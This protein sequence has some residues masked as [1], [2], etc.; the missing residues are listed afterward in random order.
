MS[1]PARPSSPEKVVPFRRVPELDS[2]RALAAAA[3][4]LFHLNP[5]Q[6]AFGWT[7][8]DLFFVLSG[9][10]ITKIIL[11]NA[12]SRG[13]FRNFYMRRGLRIWPIYYLSLFVIV[14]LNNYLSRPQD[15]TDLPYY[16]TY[17]QNVQ[18]Y[19]HREPT[20]FHVAFR[21]TWTLAL[22]EQ[23]YLIWPALVMLVRRKGLIALCLAVVA[24]AYGWRDMAFSNA[25]YSLYILPSRCDGFAL[26]GLP[27]CGRPGTRGVDQEELTASP[28]DLSEETIGDVPTLCG[29]PSPAPGSRAAWSSRAP[30]GHLH[31][32]PAVAPARAG[33]PASSACRRPPIRPRCSWPSTSSSSG[34]SASA[35]RSPGRRGWLPGALP[36]RWSGLGWVDSGIY[37][38]HYMVYWAY[39]GFGP[40][41][42]NN[43]PLRI[44]ALKVA[45]TLALAVLSWH[46]IERPI[47]GLKDRFAYRRARPA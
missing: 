40:A 11:D 37:I 47:L 39:D 6:F 26:G 36:P 45:T 25:P 33:F 8:V 20:P 35:W 31:R 19:W 9:Y 24:F 28:D 12:G 23:F 14:L 34:S 41:F 10:L 4:L 1:N 2:L 27:C 29:C 7:G 21:H 30:R 46:L 17:T 15:L 42:N 22:E 43:Q 3:V 38:Y 13:F 5:P 44:K 18:Y 32:L 16:L